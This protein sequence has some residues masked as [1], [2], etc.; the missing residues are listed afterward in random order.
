MAEIL[1]RNKYGGIGA[2]R[3]ETGGIWYGSPKNP[4]DGASRGIWER[5]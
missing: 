2:A 3:Q 5:L 4:F 1:K